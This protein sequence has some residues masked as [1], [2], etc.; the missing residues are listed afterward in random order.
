MSGFFMQPIPKP[1]IIRGQHKG[2][3]MTDNLLDTLIELRAANDSVARG[4]VTDIAHKAAVI[5][6][7]VRI[8]ENQRSTIAKLNGSVSYWSGEYGRCRD[9]LHTAN[10][11]VE[12][13]TVRLENQGR[14][15]DTLDDIVNRQRDTI[16]DLR[17][18]VHTS[19]ETADALRA[20]YMDRGIKLYKITR[21]CRKSQANN[22]RL[23]NEIACFKDR[24]KEL[25]QRNE[26]LLVLAPKNAKHWADRCKDQAMG[27]GETRK[28]NMDLS[29]RL[30]KSNANTRGLNN[31]ISHLKD[32]LEAAN[33]RADRNQLA[34]ARWREQYERAMPSTLTPAHVEDAKDMLD[35]APNWTPARVFRST[36][37]QV[38][39]QQQAAGEM[40]TT[41]GTALHK[42]IADLLA[43]ELK[44]FKFADYM[45]KTIVAHQ[46][47]PPV[48]VIDDITTVIPNDH[49]KVNTKPGTI[50]YLYSE[51][52]V[53]ELKFKLENVNSTH[54]S[55]VMLYAWP[56]D[57]A[58]NTALTY[59][60]VSEGKRQSP[61]IK[62]SMALSD[63]PSITLKLT[64]NGML[65]TLR[66]DLVAAVDE[67]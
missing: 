20:G 54:L 65:H 46:N 48:T 32:K 8:M 57:T 67:D 60:A 47:F 55:E 7:N 49:F 4:L 38:L 66:A 26:R 22:T 18:E 28:R 16:V 12:D 2:K 44:M 34:S 52:H 1:P 10:A 19:R 14:S 42:Q 36:A 59:G 43:E 50:N 23:H 39:A 25:L 6:G 41:V 37:T 31:D 58:L 61:Y 3:T 51:D 15:A 64:V 29:R 21:T 40:F 30:D 24:V 9:V 53:P 63:G 17:Q 56:A 11:R 13:L 5:N 35:R 33:T 62:A 45:G 27:L